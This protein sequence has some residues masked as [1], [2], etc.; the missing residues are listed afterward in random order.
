[1]NY[2]PTQSRFQPT[3]RSLEDKIEKDNPVRVVDAFL[4]RLDLNK[5]GS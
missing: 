2:I 3:F 4:E 5:L 1:M